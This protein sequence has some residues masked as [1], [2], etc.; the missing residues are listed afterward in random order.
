MM[1]SLNSSLRVVPFAL[2]LLI[3][4]FAST[5]CG[6]DDGDG[7][8]NGVE[9]VIGPDGGKV[10]SADG[11][12]TLDVPPGALSKATKLIV[13]TAEDPTDEA[14]SNVYELGPAGQRFDQQVTLSFKAD[15]FETDDAVVA[16]LEDD[17]W[18]AL[19][20]PART[21]TSV[22][23]DTTHFSLFA[24]VRVRTPGGMED[25]AVTRD[26]GVDE[27]VDAAGPDAA[28]DAG[29]PD[30]GGPDGGTLS[31]V[32]RTLVY[33]QITSETESITDVAA[34]SADGS[35]IAFP[36][37]PS[38]SP[39]RIFVVNADGS[40]RQQVD[41]YQPMCGCGS[42]VAI[43]ADGSTV[44]STD[45]VQIRVVTAAGSLVGSLVLS[46]NEISDI[47]LSNNGA[48]VFFIARRDA[49]LV[50][51]GAA[52]ERGVWTMAANGSGLR[53]VAGPSAV[54]TLVGGGA[55]PADVFP[56]NGCGPSLGVSADGTRVVFAAEIAQQGSG[57]FGV[58]GDGS[59]LHTLIGPV[60]SSQTAGP[61]VRHTG[62][63]SN[64]AKV[65]YEIGNVP[66][67][68]DPTEI[69]TIGFDGSA[70]TPITTNPPTPVGSCFTPF[71]ITADG[72]SLLLG[73]TGVLFPTSGGDPLSLVV[74]GGFFSSDPY[75]LVYNGN[76]IS[77]TMSDDGSRFV[78]RIRDVAAIV[79]A[80]TLEIDPASIGE[81]PQISNVA[82]TPA[83]LPRDRSPAV[84]SADVTA[85]GT[86]LRVASAVLLHGLDD[87]AGGW[88][89]GSQVLLDDGQNGDAT[90]GDD[91]YTTNLISV[92]EGG[93]V[94]PRIVRVKAEVT[95]ADGK[96]HAT[97]IDIE[98]FD[99]R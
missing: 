24:V 33:H 85:T 58:G 75:Q 77:M 49:A 35:R 4:V 28:S 79:Q 10:S 67:L 22:S 14:V 15:G 32:A 99:V 31:S 51:T 65:F 34:I 60:G 13:K 50:P 87:T 19:T 30:A 52:L 57:I 91:T 81:S 71:S 2:S 44:V 12:L 59:G 43:S 26:S 29:D 68:V 97:A 38:G 25:A 45:S 21:R 42:K 8:G 55:T 74:V 7:G 76:A 18:V 70:R 66:G 61:G 90:A 6:G 83:S 89:A 69:G 37:A 98:P 54:A 72:S 78:Y 40:G 48:N 1:T 86:A 73:D 17:E 88:T 39:N 93:T 5:G 47:A 3:A 46:S 96:R 9:K 62:I 11:L 82:I 20:S 92:G 27:P 56:F 84:L 36:I 80:V 41:S 53:Q 16:T 95:E 63:S 94:G 23:G 64:G